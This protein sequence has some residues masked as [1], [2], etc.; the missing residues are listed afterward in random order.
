MASLCGVCAL[1]VSGVGDAS[2]R[3]VDPA[4]APVELPLPAD[5][6]LRSF[7]LSTPAT[8]P[9]CLGLYAWVMAYPLESA[10][11]PW[12]G[13]AAFTASVENCSP[14]LLLRE[15]VVLEALAQAPNAAL[16]RPPARYVDEYRSGHSYLIAS[17][18]SVAGAL[19]RAR[20]AA[21]LRDD[22]RPEAYPLAVTVDAARVAVATDEA[23]LP[24]DGS[25]PKGPKRNRTPT[26]SKAAVFRWLRGGGTVAEALARWAAAGSGGPV[27]AEGPPTLAVVGASYW[28]GGR[29]CKFA[30][31]VPQSAW[32]VRGQAV[33]ATSVEAMVASLV[34]EVLGHC[35][36]PVLSASGRE[37]RDVR[38]VGPG[39]PYYLTVKGARRSPALYCE[40]DMRRLDALVL[41]R[42]GGA[43]V[44]H[45]THL[46]TA[47]EVATVNDASAD[48]LKVYRCAVRIDVAAGTPAEMGARL[49]ALPLPLR[50]D[51]ATP[52]RV[53]HRRSLLVR[54]RYVLALRVERWLEEGRV[55]VLHLETTAGTYIKEF[56]HG[57]LGRTQPSLGA[58]LGGARCTFLA[59]DVTDVRMDA[60]VPEGLLQDDLQDDDADQ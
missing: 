44:T 20:L 19:L 57:D 10:L 41:E 43:V 30:R 36:A 21:H 47:A 55:L 48:K 46:L 39:R 9:L 38:M 3:Y 11:A 17:V 23:L 13:Y 29:Y 49:H 50:V 7:L 51:Q 4:L 35:E 27:V 56:V 6:P 15:L 59:L 60:Q 1:R 26:M 45:G 32:V 52:V 53:T 28:V 16:P 5:G 58:L 31:N 18:P 40:A 25:A 42:W 24:T 54:P 34:P 14:S 22:A 37:D 33:G 8:C 12:E 2:P